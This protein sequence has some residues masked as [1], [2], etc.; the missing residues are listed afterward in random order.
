MRRASGAS[1]KTGLFDLGMGLAGR[2]GGENHVVSA[3]DY[4]PGSEK[5]PVELDNLHPGLISLNQETGVG[6]SSS[7][8]LIRI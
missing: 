8:L 3:A 6:G 2:T 5:D 7:L 4:H 1:K